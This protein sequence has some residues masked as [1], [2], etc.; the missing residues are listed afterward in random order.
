MLELSR[1]ELKL[2]YRT[3]CMTGIYGSGGILSAGTGD[4]A[5]IEARMKEL[6]PDGGRNSFEY[7]TRRQHL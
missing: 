5:A 2:G 3:S 1:D 6:Q 7:P 4:R